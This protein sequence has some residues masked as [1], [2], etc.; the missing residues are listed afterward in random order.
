LTTYENFVYD[1]NKETSKDG[2]D[3]SETNFED[4][5][6]LEDY[7]YRAQRWHL[8]LGL[9]S[10]AVFVPY[11]YTE[12]GTR[13]KPTDEIQA[14]STNTSQTWQDWASAHPDEAG[15][16]V[17]ETD[18]TESSK[19]GENSTKTLAMDLIAN[20]EYAIVMT[21]NIKSLG[22]I[23]NLYYGQYS[24]LDG[25][26]S[27]SNKTLARRGRTDGDNGSVTLNKTT[28]NFNVDNFLDMTDG[29]HTNRSNSQT[30][31]AVYNNTI[32]SDLDVD[33]LGTH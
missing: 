2:V 15:G 5:F 25:T 3:L 22:P 26:T 13:L 19:A 30:V 24:T 14:T 7:A 20:G 33:L 6:D 4:K 29:K 11:D 8:K 32:L 31:L 21:A 10:S 16:G 27:S 17:L 9:P 23:W 1:R 18:P 12:K 28:Y